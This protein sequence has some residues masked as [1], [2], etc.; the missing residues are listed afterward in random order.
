M[1][2]SGETI[3]YGP[4]AFMDTYHPAKTFSSIDHQ[5]RYAFANQGPIAHWN[6]T[7]FAET[8]LPL[9]DDDSEQAVAAAEIALDAFADIHRSELQRRFTA[10]IGLEAGD[11]DDWSLV[12]G[13]LAAMT[14]G[15]ADFT[16][17]FHRLSESLESDN[18]DDVVGLFKQ[19]NAI[20]A[21]LDSWRERLHVVDRERVVA[22]MRRTNPV[23]IPRNHRVEEAI[24][25][26]YKGDFSPFHR[27][28]E[29]LQRPFT[30]QI[31]STEYETSP[32]PDEV[33]RTTFCGT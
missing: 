25:A 30:T 31:D 26:A 6:L 23:F 7:R 24:T 8:L 1:T 21:W 12:E 27:L 20:I 16:L 18:D 33:V 32:S 22:V 13:L 17:V 29:V 5:G 28:N 10:K 2:I 3:D 4:C 11:A 19:P 15:E 9:L 14:E